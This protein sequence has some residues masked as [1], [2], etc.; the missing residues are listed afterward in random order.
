MAH[1]PNNAPHHTQALA[2][3]RAALDALPSTPDG[4]AIALRSLGLHGQRHSTTRYPLAAYAC[5]ILDAAGCRH[6]PVAADRATVVVTC[7]DGTPI[8]LPLSPAAYDFVTL[9]DAGAYPDLEAEPDRPEAPRP[10][11]AGGEE[12]RAP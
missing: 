12:P 1:A 6:W 3:L 7:P 9:F 4:I 10:P 11:A 2:S 8:T 5:R